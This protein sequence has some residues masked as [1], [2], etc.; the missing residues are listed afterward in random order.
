MGLGEMSLLDEN[1]VHQQNWECFSRG[2]GGVFGVILLV[3][4]LCGSE[5]PDGNPQPPVRLMGVQIQAG[6]LITGWA[7]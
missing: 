5:F 7:D 1:E 6:E 2:L 4:V 3:G